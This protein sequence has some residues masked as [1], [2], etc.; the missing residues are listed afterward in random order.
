MCAKQTGV[1]TAAG[2]ILMH[3]HDN[4]SNCYYWQSDNVSWN[5]RRVSVR[6][7]GRV[8]PLS[9]ATQASVPS[10]NCRIS[11]G[12]HSTKANFFRQT[13]RHTRVQVMWVPRAERVSELVLPLLAVA[14][15]ELSQG[16]AR[17]QR[18][19]PTGPR[20]S[21]SSDSSR[22]I[23]PS[24]KSHR[25]RWSLRQSHWSSRVDDP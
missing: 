20:R 8:W 10:R 17:V 15:G 2:T 24:R 4:T 25:K 1:V 16:W 19:A 23:G 5:R 9:V 11:C 12:L 3:W 13:C 14:R 7:R 21:A 22:A 18:R 6:T